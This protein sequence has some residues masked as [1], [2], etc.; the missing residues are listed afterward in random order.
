MM[1]VVSCLSAACLHV[2]VCVCVLLQT[3]A[4]SS[5]GPMPPAE[6]MELRVCAHLGRYLPVPHF[7]APRNRPTSFLHIPWMRP[8]KPSPPEGVSAWRLNGPLPG[9]RACLSPQSGMDTQG[10][11]LGQG[12]R[13]EGRPL[14]PGES[15]CWEEGCDVEEG[16]LTLRLMPLPLLPAPNSML[17]CLPHAWL[18]DADVR[19]DPV[20]GVGLRAGLAGPGRGP[21][22]AWKSF[23]KVLRQPW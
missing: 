3:R 8:D 22:L 7:W 15:G 11:V 12:S 18:T 2:W 5:W 6:R 23:Q 4:C 17:S 1:T 9:L 19:L 10:R 13:G 16:D 14:G 20:L 21:D